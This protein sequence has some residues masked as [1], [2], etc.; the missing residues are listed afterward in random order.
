MSDLAKT[1]RAAIP[2]EQPPMPPPA[3]VSGRPFWAAAVLA[4]AAIGWG[5]YGHWRRDV[6]A[7]ATQQEVVDFR[8][9]VQVATAQATASAV[10][11]TLPGN[12]AAFD[13]AQIFARATGYIAER[14]VDI[15]SR[16]HAGDLLA[17]IAAPDLDQQLQQA[18]ATLTQREAALRQAAAA[19]NQAQSNKDLANVT[20]GRI[21]VLAREGW[22]TEQ[23]A[24]QTRLG[25]AAQNASVVNAQA[26]VALAQANEQAQRATVQQL[27]ELT[28][29]EQV[30]APFDGVISARNVDVGDLI[31]GTASGGTAM[32]VLEHDNVLRVHIDVPQS[33]AVGLTDGLSAEVKVPEIPDRVFHG[34]VARNAASLTP[35]S[36]TLPVEVDVQNDEHLLHPGLFVDVTLA[37]PRVSPGVV[38]PAGAILFNGDGLR[39]ATIENDGTVKMHDVTIYRDFGTSVELR[40]GLHGGERVVVSPPVGLQDGNPVRVHGSRDGGTAANPKMSE[41]MAGKDQG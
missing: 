40:S 5:A 4:A 3:R 1:M 12:T 22:S 41:T 20:N 26:G 34:V 8:P 30:T 16:V 14:R 24:D 23:D 39:V 13:R 29:Y 7:A 37:I 21:S 32:F 10:P 33:D 11:L 2:A 6:Q 19:V 18:V 36:R 31:S 27:Q 17:R 35:G 38:V 28:G 9:F 15:G 25:L